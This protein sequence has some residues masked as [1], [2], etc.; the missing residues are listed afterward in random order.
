MLGRHYVRIQTRLEPLVR[1]W[2]VLSILTAA[3][4]A[5]SSMGSS[6]T[7]APTA[8]DAALM[9]VGAAQSQDLQA[10][11][12]VW[13]SDKGSARDNMDRQELDR[14]LIILQPCYAHDR[15]QILDE[16][17]GTIP[18]ERRVRIQLTRGSG[19]GARTKTLQ[20]QIV[21]GPSDRWYVGDTDYGSVQAD[22]C[23]PG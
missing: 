8:R 3:A 1:K 22:F 18:T 20:F 9:F 15:A 16:Q 11:S 14:R 10:M 7:G 5:R 21:R 12:S 4:C 13:G 6:Q 19:A 2:V 23:R 17:P